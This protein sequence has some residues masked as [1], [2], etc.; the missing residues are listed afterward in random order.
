MRM[1][2]AHSRITAQGQ[3]S[4][5]AEVRRRL[6]LAPGSTIDW[7]IDGDTVLVRRSR[8]FSFD[9]IRATLFPEGSP[10]PNSLADLKQGIR[11]HMRR[12]ARG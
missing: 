6:G 8:R 9:D 7:E 10:E 2:L 5:P 1:K 4:V 11:E 3:V 12:R